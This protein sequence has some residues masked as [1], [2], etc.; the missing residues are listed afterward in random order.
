MNFLTALSHKL[1]EITEEPKSSGYALQSRESADKLA[2]PVKE[3]E[4]QREKEPV[5]FL[6]VAPI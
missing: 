4:G 5:A 2:R 6:P 3:V 1:L